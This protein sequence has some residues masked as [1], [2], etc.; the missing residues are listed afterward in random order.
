[1]QGK[2]NDNDG[3]FAA[4]LSPTYPPSLVVMDEEKYV[5]TLSLNDLQN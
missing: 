5:V 1:M 2:G 4:R 3:V